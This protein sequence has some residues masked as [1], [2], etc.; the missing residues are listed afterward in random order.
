M[1]R[2]EALRLGLGAAMIGRGVPANAAPAAFP[3]TAFHN[4]A[5][6]LPD[7]LRALATQA[8]ARRNKALANLV[9]RDTV[10]ARQQW[11]RETL[12]KLIVGMPERTPLNA[13]TT[14]NLERQGYRLEK[15]IYESRPSV[16]ISANLYI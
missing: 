7:Y 9:S 4:Y 13:R 15:V 5:R 1:T 2:R 8:V 14:G 3:G 12:W 11:V 10:R 16:Y 6:C